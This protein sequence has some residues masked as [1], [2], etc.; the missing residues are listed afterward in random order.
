MPVF[1]FVVG[2]AMPLAM[3]KHLEQDR[4]LGP[5]YGRIARR[6]IALWILGMI[7]QHGIDVD[8]LP[9]HL[10]RFMSRA[11]GVDHGERDLRAVGA[12]FEAA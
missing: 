11:A 1:L 4:A 7:A 12:D 8:H 3:S 6:V 9:R 5:I 2:A 10:H